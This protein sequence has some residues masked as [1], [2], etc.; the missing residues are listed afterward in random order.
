M[1]INPK[2]FHR[3]VGDEVALKELGPTV[4]Q[5]K[6]MRGLQF[7][8]TYHRGPGARIFMSHQPVSIGLGSNR[9]LFHL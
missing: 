4:L 6:E 7:K 2:D 8:T 1:K 5:N 9:Q 3:Q